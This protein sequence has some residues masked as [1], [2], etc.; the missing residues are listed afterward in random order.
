MSVVVSGRDAASTVEAT[1]DGL[2]AQEDAP[3]FEVIFVDN[4]SNDAT[5]TIAES[6]P[7]SP[8]LIRR[9]RGDG[10]GIAR[11]EG[12]AA[13]KG[14]LLAFTDADCAPSPRWVAEGWAAALDADIVQGAVQ[15]TPGAAVGPYSRTLAVV[16]EY[17]MYETANLFV[18]RDWFDRVGGFVDWVN[19]ANA[20]PAARRIPVPDRP[21]GEDAWLAWSARRLGATT[22]FCSAALVHHAVFDGDART[23][24]AEQARVRHFPA[25]VARIPELRDVFAWR[26][27]FLNARTASFDAGS[28]GLVAAAAL[29]SPVPLL[30]AVPYV[31]STL[32]E[33][34]RRRLG[35][36]GSLRYGTALVARDTVGAVA[37]LRGS[38][39]ARTPLL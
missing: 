7:L 21:F 1:F 39:E 5:A 11:N 37:L 38:I 14:S 2:L 6:H 34:R 13:A 15:P 27:Y 16:H 17:G 23:F 33:V 26:R 32:R 35:K 25:L 28:I 3:P 20:D 29:R 36:R 9:A 19:Y 12:A 30:A 18:S 31:V 4:G 10:P 8:R 24:V 22:A